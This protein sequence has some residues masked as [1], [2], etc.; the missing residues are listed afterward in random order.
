MRSVLRVL[1]GLLLVAGGVLALAGGVAAWALGEKRTASGGGDG[2][3]F[4]AALAPVRTAGYTIV[5]PDVASVLARH[6]VARHLGDGRLT[7]TVRSATDTPAQ[8]AS[9]PST[10]PIVVALVPAADAVRYLSGTARTEVRSVGYT[11]GEQPVSTVDLT[12]GAPKGP[13]PWETAEPTAVAG[14]AGRLVTV[15][16][17]VPTNDA[18]ALVVRRSDNAADLAV[19]MTVGFAPSSWGTATTVLLIAGLLGTLTGLSLLVLRRP[20]IDP[21]HPLIVGADDGALPAPR[22]ARRRRTWRVHPE[23]VQP[24]VHVA[25]ESPYVHTAT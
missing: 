2:G 18:V 20:W 4:V 11:T 24:A 5:V 19:T 8:L 12:G 15:S 14:Q 6:G 13:P 10:Y 9:G 17:D 1:A 22:A 23:P 25:V 7:I 21:L 16:L 3:A